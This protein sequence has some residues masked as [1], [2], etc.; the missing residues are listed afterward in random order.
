MGRRLPFMPLP[1]DAL[2]AETR[3]LSTEQFGAHV[4]LMVA[5][6]RAVDCQV[7]DDDVKLARLSGMTATRWRKMK[8]DILAGWSLV[9]G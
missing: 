1:I 8:G 4:L 3:H 2:V 5:A 6:W 9:D 7:A